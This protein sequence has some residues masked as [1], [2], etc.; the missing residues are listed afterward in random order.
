[1]PVILTT[2]VISI[3]LLAVGIA[4]SWPHAQI[5]VTPADL[6]KASAQIDRQLF[7]TDMMARQNLQNIEYLSKRVDK[8]ENQDLSV[9]IARIESMVNQDHDLIKIIAV[10]MLLTMGS[11]IWKILKNRGTTNGVRPSTSNMERG[12]R[13]GEHRSA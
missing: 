2:K 7:D 10:T 11:E 12:E 4:T 5:R 9:K 1:M 13:R 3:A 6:V 8:I